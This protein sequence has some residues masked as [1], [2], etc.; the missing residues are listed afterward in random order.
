MSASRYGLNRPQPKIRLADGT[1]TRKPEDVP[2]WSYLRDPDVF[3]GFGSGLYLRANGGYHCDWEFDKALGGPAWRERVGKDLD[4]L[5]QWGNFKRYLGAIDREGLFE[6]GEVDVSPL[7]Y[8]FQFLHKD[9]DGIDA[10]VAREQLRLTL[11]LLQQE[12]GYFKD[13]ELVDE[14]FPNQGNYTTYLVSTFGQKHMVLERFGN[15]LSV[16]SGVPV[17]DIEYVIIGDSPT[18]LECGLGAFWGAK[19]AT[20]IVAA[21]S[22]LNESIR[23]N[24]SKFGGM[25][26]PGSLEHRALPGQY[27]PTDVPGEYWW[28]GQNQ[29]QARKVILAHDAPYSKGLACT[30]S[31]LACLEHLGF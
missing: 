16:T 9:G 3:A 8:R 7:A 10:L 29:G 2:E 15:H 30:E 1:I 19:N 27:Y 21:D 23:K 25:P 22:R 31:V 18:D 14:S 24:K 5:Y 12:R 11:L 13:V 26:L 6:S 17:H 20:F 4:V 28:R